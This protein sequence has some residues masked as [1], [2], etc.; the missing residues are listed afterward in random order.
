VSATN[1]FIE[2]G[3][4]PWHRDREPVL[5]KLKKTETQLAGPRSTNASH[6]RS[7]SVAE[8]ASLTETSE[9]DSEDESDYYSE[10]DVE[11]EPEEQ[12]PIPAIRPADP[13]KAVE[14]DVI[15]AVWAKK[16]VGL[17][18][19]VIRTALGE[20]WDIFKGIRD[21]W[22]AKAAS[23]QTAIDKKDQTNIKA[24]DRRVQEQRRL[25]E[26]CIGLTLKH[27]H[28]DL[29]EKYVPFSFPSIPASTSSATNSFLSNPT[30]GCKRV[31]SIVRLVEAD[32]DLANALKGVDSEASRKPIVAYEIDTEWSSV[33]NMPFVGITSLVV[34]LEIWHGPSV[35]PTDFGYNKALQTGL[36]NS[37]Q[38]SQLVRLFGVE[39]LTVAIRRVFK[40]T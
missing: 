27:G 16:N 5:K 17:S 4:D 13:S 20:Y 1:E 24:Y 12:S 8:S 21:K 18:S 37:A 11:I 40:S 9:S 30:G 34:S 2:K 10:S 26:S 25:L 15:K 29:I 35:N 36:Q 3:S 31:M 32:A 38:Q 22:K 14:Y 19:T 7:G 6:S 39:S 28:P 33:A 23:L